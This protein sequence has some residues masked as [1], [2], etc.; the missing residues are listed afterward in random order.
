MIA[1]FTATIPTSSDKPDDEYLDLIPINGRDFRSNITKDISGKPWHDDRKERFITRCLR[2]TKCEKIQNSSCFGTKIPY[3][4][5]SVELT[6]LG[7][8]ENSVRKLNQLEA[9]RNVPKCW[10]VI[11]VSTVK[12]SRFLFSF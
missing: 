7:S 10:A 9:L 6:D 8:Q 11:Q 4:F 12:W 1:E 5:T 3:K 2:P